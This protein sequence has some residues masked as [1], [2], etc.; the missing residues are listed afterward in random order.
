MLSPR[1]ITN[2][3]NSLACNSLTHRCRGV[4]LHIMAIGVRIGGDSG[5]KAILAQIVPRTAGA[6]IAQTDNWFPFAA[7]TL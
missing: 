4:L 3:N 1:V 5:P 2:D 7:F 6:F